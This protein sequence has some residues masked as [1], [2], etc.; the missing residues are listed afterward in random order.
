M[1]ICLYMLCCNI[2]GNHAELKH[3]DLSPGH[4]DGAQAQAWPI[5]AKLSNIAA[6]GR[7]RFLTD[8]LYP[9]YTYKYGMQ[10]VKFP[11]SCQKHTDMESKTWLGQ[12]KQARVVDIPP[13][14][15]HQHKLRKWPR[16]PQLIQPQPQQAIWS[17]TWRQQLAKQLSTKSS[18]QSCKGCTSALVKI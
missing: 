13:L 15:P 7:T 9:T 1:R 8:S 3:F 11:L 5:T 14:Q 10:I 2:K 18:Q 12:N 6:Y 17:L 16:Q 4:L